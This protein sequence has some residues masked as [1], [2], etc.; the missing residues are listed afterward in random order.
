[1]ACRV[2]AGPAVERIVAFA[3]IENV[4]AGG[5]SQDVIAT[6]SVHIVGDRRSRQYVVAVVADDDG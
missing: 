1:M 3:A 2:D 4:L 5:S 6:K